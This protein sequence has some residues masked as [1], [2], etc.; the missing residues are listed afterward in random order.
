MSSLV[1]RFGAG[2][3]FLCAVPGGWGGL[4]SRVSSRSVGLC[5]RCV[6]LS[7][8]SGCCVVVPAVCVAGCAA[9]C[10][11]FIWCLGSSRSFPGVGLPSSV[12]SSCTRCAVLA[13]D[14]VGAP[15]RCFGRVSLC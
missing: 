11:V 10:G 6:L 13:R 14:G 15:C 9:P 7:D 4:S 3:V 12:A 5:G 8:M 1:P 2:R